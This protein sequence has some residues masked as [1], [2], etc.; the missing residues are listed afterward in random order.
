MTDG[1]TS[2]AV[3]T[4]TPARLRAERVAVSTV[5]AVNGALF[6]NWVPRIPEIADRVHASPGLLGVVL[7]ALAGG[8]VLA[9]PYAGRLC[10]RK[11]STRVVP[12][13]GVAD[14]LALPLVA[15]AAFTG[16]A[17]VL[18]SALLVFGAAAGATDVSM[19]A[20]AVA[21]VRRAQ[22]PLMPGFHA[23]YSVGGMI[24]AGMGSLAIRLGLGL[25]TH[26]LIAAGVGV[27]AVLGVARRLAPDPP[28]AA[29][30]VE[31]V[32]PAPVRR[33]GM[34][35][36]V[37]RFDV[38]LLVFGGVALCS[39]VAE[40]A[41]AD[42]TAL[43]LR[44]VRHTTDAVGGIGYAAFA[45][46]MAVVRFSGGA[47]LRRWSPATV[48]V[49]GSAL[50]AAGILVAIG[51]PPALAAIVGFAAVGAGSGFGFPIALNAA[52]AH[53]I[54]AGPAIGIVTTLGYTGIL[55]GPPLIGGLAQLAG[56][57][58]GLAAVAVV[59][60]IGGTLAYRYRAALRSHDPSREAEPAA[61]R[62]TDGTLGVHG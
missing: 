48:L 11:S 14:A 42:W 44:D 2:I 17:A 41:M 60:A 35:A 3:P 18:A 5:F 29:T 13:A 51:L 52:G 27:V 21:I 34:G 43:F 30:P 39:G 57:R 47:I 56:L 58:V 55:L 23:L 8:G 22:R 1:S 4:P 38:L 36:L 61:H 46:S 62:P 9:M 26:F 12:W 33:R 54:G 37:R 40:G 53:R 32:E 31:P 16:S 49:A 28:V 24:G 7:L 45:V 19:N 50:T 59:A 20:N 15:V 6:G 10:E 25:A